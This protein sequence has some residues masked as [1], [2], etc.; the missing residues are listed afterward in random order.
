MGCIPFNDLD[1]DFPI[2]NSVHDVGCIKALDVDVG[3]VVVDE[4]LACRSVLSNLLLQLCFG[5]E[6]R[7]LCG[8]QA[9]GEPAA[10][11]ATEL[12][13]GEKAAAGSRL[14]KESA[15][16]RRGNSG[17]RASAHSRLGETGNR[18]EITAERE[19]EPLLQQHFQ[20]PRDLAP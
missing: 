14:R 4:K 17:R 8:E 18:E 7:D 19:Q 3:S 2:L 16:W 15:I 6:D 5:T 9:V 10:E 13:R 12:A 11:E 20:G 1:F